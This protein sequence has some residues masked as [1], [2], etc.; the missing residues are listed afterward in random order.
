LKGYY[1]GKYTQQQTQSAAVSYSVLVGSPSHKV[2]VIVPQC[3]NDLLL[4]RRGLPTRTSE[5]ATG[6]H[7]AAAA[8][9]HCWHQEDAVGDEECE[10]SG[11]GG[12]DL[13]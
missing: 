7:C 1:S 8:C 5:A 13:S 6:W 11:N 3:S 10:G 4:P 12:E 2:R 9:A